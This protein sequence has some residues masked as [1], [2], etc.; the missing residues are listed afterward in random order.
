MIK[1]RLSSKFNLT[2]YSVSVW[3]VSWQ[4]SFSTHW[5][6]GWGS[7]SGYRI[8]S[9]VMGF[10]IPWITWRKAPAQSKF[11]PH[12]TYPKLW[13]AEFVIGSLGFISLYVMACS[14]WST[15]FSLGRKISDSQTKW[16]VSMLSMCKS[17]GHKRCLFTWIETEESLHKPVSLN[18]FW[19][20]MPDLVNIL[21][22]SEL[23]IYWLFRQ[24]AWRTEFCLRVGGKKLSL[25]L[26]H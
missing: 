19:S 1:K 21:G 3:L 22:N 7:S 23:H 24:K 25:P 26:P 16:W 8:S 20:T 12:Q 6:S 18:V 9:K 13:A 15:E 17:A 4:S 2:C 11:L 10:P 5:V 14:R